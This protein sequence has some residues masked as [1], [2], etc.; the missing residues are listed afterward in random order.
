MRISRKTDYGVRVLIALARN[1]EGPISA[2]DL[3]AQMNIP[4]RFL[5]QVIRSLKQS[6][7]IK[8][9]RGFKG[10]YQ[11]SKKASE[12]TL[13]EVVESVHGP[14]ELVP[15][16]ENPPD[17]KLLNTCTA[18]SVWSGLD[19]SIRKSLGAITFD[20]LVANGLRHAKTTARK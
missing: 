8:S 5:E 7:Y 11:L 1:G 14:I 15:C 9:F 2:K 13:L 6:G 12:I 3:S 17:C 19:S 18:H 4:Y 16:L 20:K 10:G